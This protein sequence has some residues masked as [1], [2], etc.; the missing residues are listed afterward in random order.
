MHHENDNEADLL[1]DVEPTAKY[2]GVTWRQA[3][4]KL[5]QASNL[6]ARSPLAGL[7]SKNGWKT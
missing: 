5:C 7:A 2:L 4:T 6:A 3:T 1:M